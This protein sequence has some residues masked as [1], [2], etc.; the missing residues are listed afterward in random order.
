MI[1]P[2]DCEQKV[3]ALGKG[4]AVNRGF[5][6]IFRAMANEANIDGSP[7]KTMILPMYDASS[8]LQPGDWAPELHFVIRKV[9]SIGEQETG[10]AEGSVSPIRGPDSDSEVIPE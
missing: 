10:E 8:G 2:S 9:E 3:L 5:L 6:D 7:S 4:E 1:L